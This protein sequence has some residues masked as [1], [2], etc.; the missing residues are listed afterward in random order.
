MPIPA[1]ALAA[2]P[3]A[4]QFLGGRRKRPKVSDVVARY[5]NQRAAGYIS[6]E[7]TAAAG[8]TQSRIAGGVSATA[9]AQR[10]EIAN[11]L[12][13][14]GLTG[15]PASFAAYGDLNAS[16]ARGR[17][18]AATAGADVE[19]NAFN[20]NKAFE[21]QKIGAAMAAE[22]GDAQHQGA[23]ADAQ[24]AT[25]WNS[26]TELIG[27]I[28]PGTEMSFGRQ[29]AGSAAGAGAGGLN[30]SWWRS[31]PPGGGALRSASGV[32]RQTAGSR[33]VGEPIRN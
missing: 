6:P 17:E 31:R 25:W 8:R 10:G 22:L 23:R 30:P 11:R 26:I 16:E 27:A 33:R 13:R 12:V 32:V 4:A 3:A 21:E 18:A 20:R 15:A 14:S 9:K 2:I 5:R 19:Y 28:P 1:L 29:V 7:D 24:D